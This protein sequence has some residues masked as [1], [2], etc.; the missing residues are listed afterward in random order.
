MVRVSFLITLLLSTVALADDP[1]ATTPPAPQASTRHGGK[2][3]GK[4]PNGSK[5]AKLHNDVRGRCTVMESPLNPITGPCV[6]VPLEL[7]DKAGT[8]LGVSR[9]NDKGEFDFEVESDG[10]YTL[11]PSSSYYVVVAPLTTVDRGQRVDLRIR[12]KN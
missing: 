3:R 11:A 2:L 5:N 8:S 9:T 1:T 7:K 6:S 4:V 10:P 12:Q